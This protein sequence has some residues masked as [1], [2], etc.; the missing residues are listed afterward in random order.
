MAAL[1]GAFFCDVLAQV[2][3]RQ[4]FKVA[5]VIQRYSCERIAPGPRTIVVDR[6]QAAG[7]FPHKVAAR[8]DAAEDDEMPAGMLPKEPWPKPVLP[9]HRCD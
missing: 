5:A 1:P 2:P 4:H 9:N 3:R 6:P 7:S 8:M